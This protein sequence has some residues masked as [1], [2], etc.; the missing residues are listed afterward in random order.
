MQERG[1]Y[2]GMQTLLFIYRICGRRVLSFF[3][4]PVVVY[5]YFSGGASQKASKEYWQRI[6][7]IKGTPKKITHTIGIKHFYSFVQIA[8]YNINAWG[9]KFTVNDIIYS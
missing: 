1:T 8:F 7:K 6:A 3:L 2:L 5:L 4:Y 9:V